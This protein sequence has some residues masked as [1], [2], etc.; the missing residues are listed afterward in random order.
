[1]PLKLIQVRKCDGACCRE[2]PRFPNA[3]HSDC[4]YHD[5]TG[6]EEGGCMLMKDASLIPIGKCPAL[7]DKEAGEAFQN[8]CVDWPH[9]SEPLL[10][11]TGGCCWQWVKP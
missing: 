11:E 6:K 10:G 7:P 9:N 3:D 5:R 2:A 8:T 1:M 4:I